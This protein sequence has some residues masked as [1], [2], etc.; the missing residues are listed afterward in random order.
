V[1]A[2]SQPFKTSKHV[3]IKII[4]SRTFS[5]LSSR[6]LVKLSFSVSQSTWKSVLLRATSNAAMMESNIDVSN[7]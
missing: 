2:N 7:D 4:A 3:A 6:D 5:R 1:G